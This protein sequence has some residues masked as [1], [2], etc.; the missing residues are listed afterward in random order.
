MKTLE[1]QQ[2]KEIAEQLDC[3]FRA[4]IHKETLELIFIPNLD[5]YPEMEMEAWENEVNRLD[6]NFT[7]YFEV[8]GMSSTESF[9]VME[10]FMESL[11]DKTPLKEKLYHALNNKKPFS[12]F[13][14][15]IDNSGEFRQRWFKYKEESLCAYVIDQLYWLQ[16][17]KE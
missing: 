16:P 7:D 14:F 5:K 10:G 13:K 4:F 2:I 15:I 9:R 1:P 12:G 11:S 6:E 17:D 3:G 8:E